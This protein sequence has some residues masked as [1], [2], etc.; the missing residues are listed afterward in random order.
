[1]AR[2]LFTVSNKDPSFTAT[3]TAHMKQSSIPNTQHLVC[4][5]GVP[6]KARGTFGIIQLLILFWKTN[7][8]V[9]P[10]AEE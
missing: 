8:S 2:I 5:P 6:I 7:P 1:M 4:E 3:E 9:A 10:Y